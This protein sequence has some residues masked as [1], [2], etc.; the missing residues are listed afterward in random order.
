MDQLYEKLEAVS[1]VKL[2]MAPSDYFRRNVFATF[3]EDPVFTAT[4]PSIGSTNVMWSSDFPHLA[5]SFPDSHAYIDK[6]L[7]DVTDEDRRR[8]VHDNVANLY[9]IS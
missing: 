7:G 9:G 8:I 5:S 4:L 6:L 1:P 2:A 3:I